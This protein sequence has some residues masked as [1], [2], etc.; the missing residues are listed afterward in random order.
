LIRFAGA[1]L[2]SVKELPQLTTRFWLYLLFPCRSIPG[3]GAIF[4]RE[5]TSRPG[6]RHRHYPDV[7]DG[8]CGPEQA[9]GGKTAEATAADA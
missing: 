2:R 6:C 7:S 4:P 3:Q 9:A 5:I 8:D 1:G